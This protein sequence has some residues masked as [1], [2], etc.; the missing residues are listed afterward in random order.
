MK[1]EEI[2]RGIFE[3]IRLLLVSEGLLPDITLYPDTPTGLANYLA[4][5]ETLKASIFDNEIVEI[6][7][8]GASYKRGKK[9]TSTIF[10]D[11]TGE[12]KG[13]VG[14]F[15][16]SDFDEYQTED[17]EPETRFNKSSY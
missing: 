1:I 12:D 2:D 7:G 16:V 9:V 6:K 4:A 14:G 17:P 11:R 10:V 13:D 5:K 8:V 15:A 3:A